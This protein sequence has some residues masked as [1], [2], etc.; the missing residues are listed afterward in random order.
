MA[1]FKEVID[2]M[3]GQESRLTKMINDVH[4]DVKDTNEK[5]TKINGRLRGVEIKV[6]ERDMFCQLRG[7]VVD[8]KLEQYKP[9]IKVT[10]FLHLI[11]KNPK[12][13]LLIFLGVIAT[14]QTV[15]VSAVEKGWLIKIIQ[16]I[17]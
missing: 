2:L 1:S 14:I 17:K 6:A 8:E 11:T 12:I 13:T 16:L 15:V 5:V 4:S 3:K 10:R 7:I 9:T